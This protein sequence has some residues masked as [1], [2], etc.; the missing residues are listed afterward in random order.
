MVKAKDHLLEERL[1][2]EVVAVAV[3]QYVL[4]TT[5]T[6]DGAAEALAELQLE[7]FDLLGVQHFGRTYE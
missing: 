2:A 7:A 3:K 5:E 6:S 4:Q 1:D